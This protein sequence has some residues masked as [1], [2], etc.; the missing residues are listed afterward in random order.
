MAPWT[1]AS[2]SKLTYRRISAISADESSLAKITRSTPISSQNRTACQ[3][4]KLPW[5]EKCSS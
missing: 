2:S 5:V 1:K 3:L 4:V